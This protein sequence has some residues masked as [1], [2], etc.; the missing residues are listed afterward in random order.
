MTTTVAMSLYEKIGG[1]PAVD[2]AVDKFYDKVLAD[3]RIKHFFVNT[4]M[5][6]QRQHQK[7]FLTWAFGGQPGYNGRGMREA[8]KPLVDKLGLNDTHFDAVVENLATTLSEL[9]VSDALI[10]EVAKIAESIR[11]E[12][13]CR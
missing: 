5:A 3:A 11:D 10:G 4:D 8:H 6:K 13:L 1:A 12:V 7:T 9:G 2:A